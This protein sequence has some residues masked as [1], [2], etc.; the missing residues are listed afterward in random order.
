MVR[1]GENGESEI[2]CRRNKRNKTKE[3]RSY[4]WNKKEGFVQIWDAE[5]ACFLIKEEVRLNAEGR[6]EKEQDY[7]AI[8]WSDLPGS[9]EELQS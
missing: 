5:K 7:Q 8:L 9:E 2:V 3:L 6:P 4:T 1:S